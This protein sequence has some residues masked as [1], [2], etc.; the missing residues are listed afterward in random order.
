MI[1]LL[2]FF[3]LLL[4]LSW[5]NTEDWTWPSTCTTPA[6]GAGPT[7]P[8]RSPTNEASNVDIG[9]DFCKQA[10]QKGLPL[11]PTAL[12]RALTLSSIGSPHHRAAR[13]LSRCRQTGRQLLGGPP[14]PSVAEAFSGELNTVMASQ[15][16]SSII[17]Y[18]GRHLK[19]V[20]PSSLDYVLTIQDYHLQSPT[21]Q[22]QSSLLP[23]INWEPLTNLFHMW[24]LILSLR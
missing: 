4:I 11:T 21:L 20:F 23:S 12:M 3:S 16:K 22:H 13:G 7:V 18:I 19:T 10:N 14:Y 8:N 2:R 15:E 6:A 1:T 9:Q 5:G 17:F 24:W